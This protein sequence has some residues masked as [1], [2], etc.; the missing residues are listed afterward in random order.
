MPDYQKTK[1]YKIWSPNSEK[2]YVGATVQTLAQ[3][4]GKHRKPSNDTQS[5]I[6]IDLGD[7]R[8]ELIEE[9][10]CNNK[11]E[12]NKKEGEYI[13]KL[14]CVNKQIAGRSMKEWCDEHKNELKEKRKEY[15]KNN[16]ELVAKIKHA[17]YEKNKSHRLKQANLYYEANKEKIAI[18]SKKYYDKN[19]LEIAE[20]KKVYYEANSEK[21]IE[22]DKARK[23]RAKAKAKLEKEQSLI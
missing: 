11:M 3:R 9:F 17:S 2:V 19:K 12:S 15:N 14:D 5:K 7:A 8:I 22:K 6:I 10:A 23:D 20:K 21:I 4:M 1:I 13:R 18:A 16:K